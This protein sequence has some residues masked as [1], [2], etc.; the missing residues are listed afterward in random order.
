[1]KNPEPITEQST[2]INGV[3][4]TDLAL[5]QLESYQKDDNWKLNLDIDDLNEVICWIV[6]ALNEIPE[7]EIKT[8]IHMMTVINQIKISLTKLRKP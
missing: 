7:E 1:M 5:E 4:L 2:I 6:S 8:A 3:I